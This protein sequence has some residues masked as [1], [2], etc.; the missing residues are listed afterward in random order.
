MMLLTL[1]QSEDGEIL[2]SMVQT[3]RT[4]V[5]NNKPDIVERLEDY[6]TRILKLTQF[7]GSMVSNHGKNISVFIK[8][9]TFNYQTL[10]F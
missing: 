10:T 1:E 4:I 2:L 6:V 9:I 8:K 7:Q 5:A 3:I